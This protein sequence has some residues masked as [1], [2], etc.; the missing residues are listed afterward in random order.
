MY[1]TDKQYYDLL[2]RARKSLDNIDRVS[3]YDCTV[4]GNKSTDTNIGLCDDSL[5]TKEIAKFPQ[6]FPHNKAL[7]YRKKHHKCPLD[8]RKEP[9]EFGCFYKCLFFQKG[10][11]DLEKIKELYD[12]SLKPLTIK[13]GGGDCEL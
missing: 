10:L 8:W 3:G 5:T 7:K 4:V 1:L 13:H 11:K 6:Y 12:E 9:E 2:K